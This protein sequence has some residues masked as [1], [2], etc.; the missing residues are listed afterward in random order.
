MNGEFRKKFL[1]KYIALLQKKY[2]YFT[3]FKKSAGNMD[4]TLDFLK[5]YKLFNLFENVL[6]KYEGSC[7]YLGPI[8]FT[9]LKIENGLFTSFPL[10]LAEMMDR[11]IEHKK[12][13]PL[14]WKSGGCLSQ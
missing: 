3:W 8:F 6:R 4:E 11:K 9:K 1:N 5:F 10:S 7:T 14:Y 12:S 13:L 2:F